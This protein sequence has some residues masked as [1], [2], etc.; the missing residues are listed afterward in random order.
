MVQMVASDENNPEFMG[1][2][3]P[4]DLLWIRFYDRACPNEWKSNEQDRPVFDN[5][6]YI[7][8][9]TPGNQL[10]IID[11]AALKADKFRFPK[12]WAF[13]EQTHSGDPAKQGT[14]LSQWPLLTIADVEMLRAQKFF[15][16]EQIAF[17]SDEQ[18]GKIGMFAGTNGMGLR[19]KAKNFL[20][21]AKDNSAFNKQAEE[22]K[23]RDDKITA[24]EAKQAESETKHTEE[25]KAMQEKMDAILSKL[26]EPAKPK[27][28]MT[29]EHKAKL[30][31][32]REAK[33]AV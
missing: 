21:V 6:V 13:Y 17:A 24:M 30:K 20:T 32:A 28:V 29:A 7:E 19:I 18:V 16:V 8:I 25:M 33:K 2:R 5:I 31:A 15:S 27:Y 11:R 22:L 26:S 14:P 23:A 1:A 12:Q 3:N 10:N 9:H 4:D